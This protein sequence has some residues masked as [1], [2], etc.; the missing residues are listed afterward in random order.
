[1]CLLIFLVLVFL[2]VPGIAPSNISITNTGSTQFT[3]NWDPISRKYYNGRLLGYRVYFQ[4]FERYYCNGPAESWSS[5]D[6]PNL[7]TRL[8]LTGLKPGQCYRVYVCAFTEIGEG[9]RRYIRHKT[10]EPIRPTTKKKKENSVGRTSAFC[11]LLFST[12]VFQ[13]LLWTQDGF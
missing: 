12:L 4:K 8:T 13:L 2:S 3:V 9:A 1:M 7:D 11:L 10:L 5:V 6:V